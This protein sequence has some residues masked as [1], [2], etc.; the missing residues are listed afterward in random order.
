M[1]CSNTIKVRWELQI[2][3]YK[4]SHQCENVTV[5]LFLWAL[6][7]QSRL[8]I[9]LPGRLGHEEL[10]KPD[11]WRWLSLAALARLVSNWQTE[12]ANELSETGQQP[13]HVVATNHSP[14]SSSLYLLAQ[15]HIDYRWRTESSH[16]CE[17]RRIPAFRRNNI[18]LLIYRMLYLSNMTSIYVR[19]SG[20]KQ[21]KY[22]SLQD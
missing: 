14:A 11:S 22:T 15:H 7:T 5:R 20:D 17:A 13:E 19:S 4:I 1:Q 10:F 18:N 3:T 8:L 6:E 12:R 21:G 9:R 2:G 16:L